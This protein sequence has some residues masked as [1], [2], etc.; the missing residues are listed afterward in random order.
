MFGHGDNGGGWV[1]EG[2]SR[3]LSE[4]CEIERQVTNGRRE[5]C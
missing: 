4:R 3:I 5:K 2:N 1:D